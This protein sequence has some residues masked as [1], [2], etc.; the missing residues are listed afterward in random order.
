MHSAQ[1]RAL[2]DD[3]GASP[4][5]VRLRERAHSLSDSLPPVTV[6]RPRGVP[7]TGVSAAWVFAP[8]FDDLV[9]L[10]R[11]AARIVVPPRAPPTNSVLIEVERRATER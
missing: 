10:E 4:K 3:H 2:S 9:V 11:H 1:R 8:A 7:S 5:E 6:A